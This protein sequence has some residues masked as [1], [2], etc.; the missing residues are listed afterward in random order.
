MGDEKRLKQVISN[1]LANA[2][3]FTPE[4]GEISFSAKKAEEENNNIVLRFEVKDNGIGIS[5]DQQEAL[6]TMFEQ[7]DGGLTR[8]HGGIGIGL[9]LSRRIIEM[10]GGEIWIESELDKGATFSFTGNFRKLI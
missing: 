2:V 8:K 9:A 10:M 3:K 1:L 7:V 5:E 6:F 4:N